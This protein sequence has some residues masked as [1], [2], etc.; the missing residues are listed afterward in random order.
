[1]AY[2][3][4]E[5][6]VKVPVGAGLWP[7]FWMLGT[8]IDQVNW[9]QTGEIDIME[10]V[11]R[12]PYQ[13]FGTL[14]GPGY[15][16][17][18]SYGNVYTLDVPVADEFH[19]FA[20]EWQPD[21][22]VWFLDGMEYFSAT[23]DDAFLQG[24]QWVFNHPFFI[25]LNVAVGGNFGGAVGP[26]T[27]FPQ[28]TL[29]DY[30][31]VYQAKPQ[32]VS[33]TA[34]FVDNFSGWQEVSLPFSAFTN[35]DGY[36]LDTSAV[37]SVNFKIPGGTRG[38]VMIDQLRLNCS[39]EW[40]VTSAADSGPGSLRRA[41]NG[42]CAGGTISFAP[43][44]SGE[45]ITLLS[46]PLTLGKDVHIDGA[47]AP[48]LTI[49]GNNTDRV[50]IVNAGTT[51]MLSHL[52][53]ADGFGWQLAGGILN[54]GSLTL[55]HVT[56]TRNIMA[57]DAGDYWQGGGGI[58]NGENATFH[59]IDSSVTDNQA[60]WSGGG[61]YSFF[62]TTNTIVRSTISGNV[63]NDVGGGLRSLGNF[64]ITDSTFSGNTSTGWHGGAIF[65]TDGAMTISYTSVV[66]NIAPDGGS[67]A[68]FAGSFSAT[69]PSMHIENSLITGN[70]WYACDRWTGTVN[71]TT[72]G[73]NL[74][75]DDS[76]S[77]DPGDIITANA[78]VGPLADNG[79]PTF[80]H[81]LM[82]GSLAIDAAGGTC[83][84]TDQR[85]IIRPQGAGCDIGAYELT[86]P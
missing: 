64:T 61:V 73:V 2:G 57:T 17:G 6:R 81:A 74:V 7:A 16:G 59:L 78:G 75:Q 35:P 29:V 14:H 71:F 51:A 28:T 27:V 84:A 3:R 36:T 5:A 76:C 30:V 43:E 32:P 52:T 1:M 21:R 31:R 40:T 47:A 33:F 70:Q 18:D 49:S 72:G 12:E 85:G 53:V 48:G 79:G 83:S 11:A 66:N 55:D 67:S 20:I 60:A 68:I 10:H 19:Q 34:S 62:N 41:I 86:A 82:P 13:V 54:N 24:K 23:P 42:V 44:L 50:F 8:D 65:H 37:H 4:I 69:V 38:P 58:Y 46:G 26:D 15:S 80:T 22:I 39:S 45:T 25:L 77:P 56:V 63:S 9:P